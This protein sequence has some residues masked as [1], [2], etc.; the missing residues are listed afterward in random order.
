MSNKK[1]KQKLESIDMNDFVYLPIEDSENSD[2]VGV[3]KKTV[4]DSKSYIILVSK[5]GN[6]EFTY[7]LKLGQVP[8][9]SFFENKDEFEKLYSVATMTEDEIID[10]LHEVK[11]ENNLMNSIMESGFYDCIL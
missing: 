3:Y 9:K 4:S 2:V 6:N 8:S 5:F 7:Q 1:L 10:N 11:N